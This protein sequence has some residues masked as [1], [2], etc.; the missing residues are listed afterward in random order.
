MTKFP[1]S[2]FLVERKT[3]KEAQDAIE[4][5]QRVYKFPNGYGASVICHSGSLDFGH[6]ISVV[7]NNDN[8][9]LINDESVDIINDEQLFNIINNMSYLLC[10]NKI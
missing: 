6:Y 8:W 3:F 9:Y 5:E 2:K 1:Q 10:Y 4:G 7:N